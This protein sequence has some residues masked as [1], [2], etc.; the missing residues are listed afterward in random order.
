MTPLDAKK[1][2]PKCHHVAI[3]NSQKSRP[4]TLG[5]ARP[6]VS[7][8][9]WPRD[10]RYRNNPHDYH[11]IRWIDAESRPKGRHSV[12]LVLKLLVM[13]SCN[14][15]HPRRQSPKLSWRSRH[16][17]PPRGAVHLEMIIAFPIFMIGLLAVIEFGLMMTNLQQVALASRIGAEAA[18]QTSGLSSASGV[19]TG[20]ALAVNRHLDSAGIG[21]SGA[22]ACRIILEHNV[23]ATPPNTVSPVL[24]TYTARSCACSA[25]GT[26]LPPVR[27]VRVTVCTELTNLTPN[28]LG[29]LGLDIKSRTVEHS[30][31]FRYE[32]L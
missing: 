9:K 27:S 1:S 20:V 24:L 30:T 3:G 17:G 2:R 26:D 13:N 11:G 4:L 7:P 28:L 8:E 14:S 15:T 22:N 6:A 21:P 19:P 32:D 25:P 5:N 12:R 31:T 29:S 16:G 18:A 10:P 23:G